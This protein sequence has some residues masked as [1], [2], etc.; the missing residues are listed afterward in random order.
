MKFIWYFFDHFYHLSNVNIYFVYSSYCILPH[1]LLHRKHRSSSSIDLFRG[2][3]TFY[4]DVKCRRITIT[5]RGF[6]P[7]I[8]FGRVLLRGT[9][10]SV[11]F[12]R[13]KQ[14]EANFLFRVQWSI[15]TD[16][17]HSMKHQTLRNTHAGIYSCNTNGP[18]G[19][20]KLFS[21]NYKEK[22]IFSKKA[23]RICS[24]PR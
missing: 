23:R 22:F 4:C 3:H 6:P 15:C 19:P 9:L 18:T 14:L 11:W 16:E 5:W 7:I 1:Y 17:L 12:Y 10:T 20:W 13:M 8:N 2:F 24:I 21:S